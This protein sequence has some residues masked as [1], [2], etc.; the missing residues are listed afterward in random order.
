M[1][2]MIDE[3]DVRQDVSQPECVGQTGHARGQTLENR[4]DHFGRSS[5]DLGGP[6]EKLQRACSGRKG[7][8]EPGMSRAANA[9]WRSGSSE[10]VSS[11]HEAAASER[12]SRPPRIIGEAQLVNFCPPV[13]SKTPLNA[14]TNHLTNVKRKSSPRPHARAALG[15]QAMNRPCTLGVYAR[16]WPDAPPTRHLVSL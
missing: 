11:K 12:A 4:F 2:P 13:G 10:Q 8:N 5:R 1:K 14:A 7:R 3:T 16:P 6:E 9:E 15:Q